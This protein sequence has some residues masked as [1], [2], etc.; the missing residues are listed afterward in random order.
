MWKNLVLSVA[1]LGALSCAAPAAWAQQNKADE[2]FMKYE[3]QGLRGE[4]SF[5]AVSTIQSR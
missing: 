4:P 5:L 3:P 2:R 1:L